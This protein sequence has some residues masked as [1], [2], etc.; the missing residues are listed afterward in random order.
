MPLMD[1]NLP[2]KLVRYE[3]L[4]AGYIAG[5]LRYPEAVECKNLMIELIDIMETELCLEGIL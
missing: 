3:Q 5:Y 4:K 2:K 1:K